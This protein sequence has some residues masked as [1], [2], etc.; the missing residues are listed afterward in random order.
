MD[1]ISVSLAINS[2]SFRNAIFLVSAFSP[3]S[4]KAFCCHPISMNFNWKNMNLFSF[5]D[6]KCWWYI[7]V[8]HLNSHL[9]RYCVLARHFGSTALCW[10]PF[11]LV[12]YEFYSSDLNLF[13]RSIYFS[14]GSRLLL[15][16]QLDRHEGRNDWW[17]KQWDQSSSLCWQKQNKP[18]NK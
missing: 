17:M 18:M 14:M 13:E 15:T 11:L 10:S 3:S 4:C 16:V 1:E 9:G 6:T 8:F 2:F 7:D 5:P 12:W